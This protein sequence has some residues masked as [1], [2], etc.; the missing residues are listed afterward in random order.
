M[1]KA[2]HKLKPRRMWALTEDPMRGCV[3]YC[4]SRTHR[5]PVVVVPLRQFNR[6]I[7]HQQDLA[8][9]YQKTGKHFGNQE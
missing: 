5:V 2:C 1:K 4:R 3:S 9:W 8:S 7:A 6:L